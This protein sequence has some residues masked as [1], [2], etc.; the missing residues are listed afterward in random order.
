[1][2]QDLKRYDVCMLF[3]YIKCDHT[4]TI[5][6]IGFCP[7]PG[8]KNDTGMLTFVSVPLFMSK[9]RLAN[10]IIEGR[11][12]E[13]HDRNRFSRYSAIIRTYR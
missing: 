2:V 12:S 5:E 11:P 1:M 10:M 9:I 13:E 4:G 8:R 7:V 6:R 3:N